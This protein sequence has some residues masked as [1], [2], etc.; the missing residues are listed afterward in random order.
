MAKTKKFKFGI[1]SLI[2]WGATVVI[3]GL[4][5]KIL[6]FKGGEWMIGIGL[7]VEALLFFIMGF[8]S[9]EKAPDW[10]RVFPELDEDYSGDLSKNTVNNITAPQHSTGQSQALDKMLNDAEITPELIE[11]LGQGLRSFGDKVASIS[12]VADTASATNQF[13]DK[14]NQ[15]SSGAAQLSSAFERAASD[16]Q[17]FNESSADMQQF[18]EQI[19]TF[20]KNLASL[21]SI[22]G[23][24]LS[25]M[26]PNR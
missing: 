2:N 22:Y 4:M 17:T 9:A 14:L 16:L 19:S 8:V 26:T 10:T 18:K 23:N 1:N 13:A 15:A 6:S 24:M 5:F 12:K 20:N 3:I 11:S 7:A 25:A 21:N